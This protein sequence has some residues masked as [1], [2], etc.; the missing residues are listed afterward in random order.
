MLDNVLET[1]GDSSKLE[2]HL[3]MMNILGDS[4][5]NCDSIYEGKQIVKELFFSRENFSKIV[6]ILSDPN[7][8]S[9]GHLPNLLSLLVE[10]TKKDDQ[11]LNDCNPNHNT[12]LKS[13]LSA[14]VGTIK[15]AVIS[16]GNISKTSSHGTASTFGT[17]NLQLGRRNLQLIEILDFIMKLSSEEVD[18]LIFEACFYQNIPVANQ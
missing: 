2:F 5:Q 11:E 1:T 12:V 6:N 8:K 7:R 3:G 13:E 10:Y 14:I 17:S 18:K 9:L 15:E 4:V 16:L